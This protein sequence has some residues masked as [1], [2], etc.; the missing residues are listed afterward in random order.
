MLTPLH[1]TVTTPVFH[2]GGICL[3]RQRLGLHSHTPEMKDV[4]FERQHTTNCL[5]K[6]LILADYYDSITFLGVILS[7]QDSGLGLIGLPASTFHHCKSASALQSHTVALCGYLGHWGSSLKWRPDHGGEPGYHVVYQNGWLRMKNVQ[8]RWR[9]KFTSNPVCA[10]FISVRIDL[11]TF[12]WNLSLCSR[13][14]D[15]KWP[16]FFSARSSSSP[17][18]LIDSRQ[19][20]SGFLDKLL[21][22]LCFPICSLCFRSGNIGV[23]STFAVWHRVLQRRLRTRWRENQNFNCFLIP[24][25]WDQEL[26]LPTVFTPCTPKSRCIVKCPDS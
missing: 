8:A 3:D 26:A 20:T 19:N 22:L 7:T 1:S 9:K 14:F 23:T 10:P 18:Q 12:S 5:L 24:L 16:P 15:V 6:Y 25:K 17:E 2:S 21:T 13:A 11:M 4:P